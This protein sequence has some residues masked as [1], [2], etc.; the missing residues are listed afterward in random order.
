MIVKNLYK[1]QRKD[2]GYD[3][4]PIKPE[5]GIEYTLMYRLIASEGKALTNDGETLY[6][7]I[8]VESKEGWYEVDSPE[9]ENDILETGD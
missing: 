2:D 1:Y 8:D 6:S 5:E 9:P 3:I 4:S 7:C